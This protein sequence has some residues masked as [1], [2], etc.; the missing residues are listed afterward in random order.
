MAGRGSRRIESHVSREPPR[1]QMIDCTSRSRR[2]PQS[3]QSASKDAR[4]HLPTK[5]SVYPLLNAR[6]RPTTNQSICRFG[7]G[8]S[9]A[10]LRRPLKRKALGLRHSKPKSSQGIRLGGGNSF[11]W[12]SC[13]SLKRSAYATLV[14]QCLYLFRAAIHGVDFV[15]GKSARVILATF[16]L[17]RA[18]AVHILATNLH[19]ILPHSER[20]A[21]YLLFAALYPSLTFKLSI[22][23]SDFPYVFTQNQPSTSRNLEQLQSKV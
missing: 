23:L 21:I 16:Q 17:I 11:G 7:G 6:W 3:M 2:M 12:L 1:C 10:T 5:A 14:Y 13:V 9:L 20:T 4:Y 15:R 18:A 8:N 19:Q 22:A